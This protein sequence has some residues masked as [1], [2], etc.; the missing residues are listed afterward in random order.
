MKNLNLN[1][2]AVSMAVLAG[3]VMVAGGAHAADLS[4]GAGLAAGNGRATQQIEAGVGLG[5]TKIGGHGVALS[6][7]LDGRM[8]AGNNQHGNVGNVG[9][10]TVLSGVSETVYPYIRASK[11]G[12]GRGLGLGALYPITQQIVVAGEVAGYS[13]IDGKAAGQASVTI[14]RHF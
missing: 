1:K 12:T 3:L 4:V 8:I 13:S 7:Y 14:S 6:Y 10:T 9:L 11:G 5:D 2:T